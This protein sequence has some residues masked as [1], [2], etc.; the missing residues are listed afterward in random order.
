[1]STSLCQD[2]IQNK[3]FSIFG[4]ITSCLQKKQPSQTLC[5]KSIKKCQIISFPLSYFYKAEL[6]VEREHVKHTTLPCDLTR[7]IEK[8]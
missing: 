6:R 8:I 5:L 2:F 1:M 3:V 4:I 7:Q